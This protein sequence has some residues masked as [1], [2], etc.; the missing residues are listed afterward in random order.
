MNPLILIVGV[1]LFVSGIVL[2]RQS[3]SPSSHIG[4]TP[5]PVITNTITPTE[6]PPASPTP[7]TT[8]STNPNPTAKPSVTPQPTAQP[9]QSSSTNFS[10]FKYPGSSTTTDTS[11]QLVLSSSDDPETITSW[12]ENKIKELGY[13]SQSSAKTNTNGNVLNK[14]AGG[15]NGASVAIQIQRSSGQNSTTIT[16]TA[17]TDSGSDVHIQIKNNEPYM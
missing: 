11:S 2:G 5:T 17:G 10:D 3:Q 6:T 4:Q 12:Y 7:T 13:S 16:I 1:F 14:L 9:Q 15:K 8:L